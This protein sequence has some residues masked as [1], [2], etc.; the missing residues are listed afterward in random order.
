MKQEVVDR[1]VDD[2]AC[3]LGIPRNSLNV[4]RYLAPRR[5]TLLT[6]KTAAAKGLVAGSFTIMREDGMLVNGNHDQEVCT[7]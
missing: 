5:S 3:T 7:P 4:V 2:L 1:Y 6:I